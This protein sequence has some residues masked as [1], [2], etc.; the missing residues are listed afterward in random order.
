MAIYYNGQVVG[1]VDLT[2]N[3]EL[4]NDNIWVQDTEPENAPEG[5]I[6]VDTSANAE[7]AKNIVVDDFISE[8]ST[9]PVESKVIKSYVDDALASA[10]EYTND[11]KAQMVA[12]VE[13]QSGAVSGTITGIMNYDLLV[14]YATPS[15]DAT[16]VCGTIPIN[17]L[18][19]FYAS[20]IPV[21]VADNTSFTVFNFHGNGFYTHQYSSSGQGKIFALYGI[22]FPH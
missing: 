12:L 18:K 20:E 5:S 8:D 19:G 6:W 3:N 21:Q 22:T 2:I 15:P 16:P 4:A 7:D 1:N 17:G 14:Y 13:N 11:N 9:N 10:K